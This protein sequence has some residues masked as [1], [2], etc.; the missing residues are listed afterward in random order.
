MTPELVTELAQTNTVAQMAEHFG[1]TEGSVR[2]F[3]R[4]HGIKAAS[5]RSPQEIREIYLRARRYGIR[6]AMEK[7]SLTKHQVTGILNREETRRKKVVAGFTPERIVKL[8]GAAR[9]RASEG[10]M[11]HVADDFASFVVEYC[12]TG[13]S[14][15]LDSLFVDYMRLEYGDL[16]TKDGLARSRA[17]IAPDTLTHVADEES[18]GE[19][20]FAGEPRHHPMLRWARL[21]DRL[22][23]EGYR[24]RSLFFLSYYLQCTQDEIGVVFGFSGSR[25][26]QLMKILNAKI[27]KRRR[28]LIDAPEDQ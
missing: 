6:S 14:V 16:D 21:A 1:R 4:K 5:G 17:T 7:F 10:N 15:N 23:I 27:A 28:A 24:W 12:L 11:G 13:N 2:H 9:R 26:S 25:I 18:S 22:G 8:R 3:M 19:E 20:R